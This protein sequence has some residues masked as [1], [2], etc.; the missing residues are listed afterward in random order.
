[1]DAVRGQALADRPAV[2]LRPLELQLVEQVAAGRLL[3]HALGRLVRRR[4]LARA[5]LGGDRYEPRNTIRP[6][7]ERWNLIDFSMARSIARS[8][9]C[10]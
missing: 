2:R 8:F 1:M 10:W 6:R 4:A 7:L 9:S 3:E 5:W